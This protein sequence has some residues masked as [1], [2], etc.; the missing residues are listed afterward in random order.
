MQKIIDLHKPIFNSSYVPDY[1]YGSEEFIENEPW[2]QTYSGKRF[3]IINPN[4]DSIVIQDIAHPLSMQCRFTGHT[5]WFYSVAQHCVI[6]SY[7]CDFEDA[8]WGLLHDASEAYITDISSPLKRSGKVDSYLEIEKNLQN[9][10]CKRFS[11]NPIEPESVKIADKVVLATEAR[12]L[13]VPLR[14]DWSLKENPL[15]FKIEPLN[16]NEAKTLFLKRFF[17]L[18]NQP[19]ELYEEYEKR[20]KEEIVL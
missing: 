11:L 1:L 19:F 2:I 7:I 18:V 5:N 14:S 17:E 10:I 9:T 4:I 3:N 12:D 16:P 20:R 15:P 6:V 13:L 8:L